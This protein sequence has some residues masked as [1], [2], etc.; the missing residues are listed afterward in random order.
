MFI[1]AKCDLTFIQLP[2]PDEEEIDN[3]REICEQA[4]NEEPLLQQCAE[5]FP[6]FLQEMLNAIERAVID[7]VVRTRFT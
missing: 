5:A 2:Q 7:F 4:F 6:D 3:A 1:N